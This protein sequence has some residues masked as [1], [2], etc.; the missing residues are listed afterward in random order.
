[1]FPLTQF[2][3]SLP[4][5]ELA[6]DYGC[7]FACRQRHQLTKIILVMLATE[8]ML[9]LFFDT[10]LYLFVG[11][12][13]MRLFVLRSHFCIPSIHSR[14]YPGCCRLLQTYVVDSFI[15]APP[16]CSS[17]MG[18]CPQRVRSLLCPSIRI[19]VIER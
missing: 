7:R 12:I 17:L 15:D 10:S 18:F 14:D 1:M 6:D 19:I 2:M 13:V 3:R 9:A 4:W 5:W 8:L 11:A 16:V